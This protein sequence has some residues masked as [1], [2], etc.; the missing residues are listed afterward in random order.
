VLPP[1]TAARRR[2]VSAAAAILALLALAAGCGSSN[3]SG[4]TSIAGDTLRVYSSQPLVGEL[5]DQGRDMVRA[6]Q[7]ALAEAGGRVGRWRVDYKALNS[8]D[9]ARGNWDPGLVSSNARTA[10][11]DHKTIA[12]LGEMDTGASAVAIP[13]LNETG[14]LEVSP[15][16]GVAGLTRERNAA[17]GEPEKYYPARDRNFVR[18]VP[19]DDLQADALVELLRDAGVRRLYVLHDEALYGQSLALAITREGPRAGITPVQSRGVDPRR[20]KPRD[21]AADVVSSG[22]DGFV[23]TGQ[24]A[25]TVPAIF[26][27]VHAAAPR[28]GLFAPGALAD[29]GFA[30]RLGAAGAR[31]R[32]LAPWLPARALPPAGR[33]FR[34]RFREHYGADPAPSAVYGYEAMRLVLAAIRHAGARGNRRAAVIRTALRARAPTSALGGYAVD[35][36]GDT[37]LRGFAVYAIRDGHL[38]Y[39][40]PV[41]P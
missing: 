26:A 14:I 13:I 32:V 27:A 20:A 16:D 37:S 2:R 6:E 1:S 18:L 30:A 12:Y 8:A 25:E 36:A 4:G 29:D 34:R 24:L 33:A 40:R 11:Q 39:V 28:L 38:A 22:A 15:S 5:A 41:E 17:P 10:A 23:Y 31:T 35:A 21:V 7:L 19:P 9:V 3:G